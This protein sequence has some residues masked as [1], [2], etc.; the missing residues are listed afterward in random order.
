MNITTKWKSDALM[1]RDVIC[2]RHVTPVNDT[3]PHVLSCDC[4]CKPHE[5]EDADK[6]F[7]HNAADGRETLQN[8][9]GTM[10]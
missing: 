6:L 3:R 7:V 4:W 1:I 5:V 8:H 2:Q 9:E 10:H